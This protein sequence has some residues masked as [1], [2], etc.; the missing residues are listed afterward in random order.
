L[1]SLVSII[2]PTYKRPFE[3][4]SRAINSVL[5]QSYKNIEV[6]VVDDSPNDF[7]N[8]KDIEKNLKR[9]VDHRVRYIQHPCNKGACAARN[10]GI[11]N[12]SGEYIAFL[13]DD[14][15]WLPDKLE[16]QL[17]KIKNSNVGLIYCSS[18]TITLKGNKQVKK[19][20]KCADISGWVY[21]KL[22]MEN[23]I[24]STSF[25]LIKKEVIESCGVFNNDIL[26]AQ[27]YELYL[28]ISKKYEIGFVNIPLVNYYVH[29]GERISTNVNNKIQGLEKVIELNMDYLKSNPKAMAIRR[30]KITPYYAIRHGCKFALLKLVEATRVYPFQI[31][32]LKYLLRILKF[33]ISR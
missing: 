33:C 13:D 11:N 12:S 27:D 15:E 24:G 22:I 7:S 30:L 5:Y 19:T 14:D 23:F 18:Y 2:I 26:S 21:D 32:N 25:V 4:L 10:T 3:I 9:I 29:E 6:I 17:K 28:R 31:E 1:N 20:V 16:L 8:R